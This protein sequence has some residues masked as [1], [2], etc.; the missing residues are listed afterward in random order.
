MVDIL[1]QKATLNMK[2]YDAIKQAV[3]VVDK[4]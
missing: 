1:H 4:L 2:F 3:P